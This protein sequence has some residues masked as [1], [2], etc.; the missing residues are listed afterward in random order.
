MTMAVEDQADGG[1]GAALFVSK[2]AQDA[3][4]LEEPVVPGDGQSVEA[5]VHQ[6]TTLTALTALC[7]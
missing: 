6:L 7:Q 4:V 3:G 5:F 2:T 1:N